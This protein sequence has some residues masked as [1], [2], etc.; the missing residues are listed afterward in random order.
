METLTNTLL[1]AFDSLLKA[2]ADNIYMAE[3]YSTMFALSKEERYATKCD[4]HRQKAKEIEK[5]LKAAYKRA[6]TI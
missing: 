3:H 1:N 2:H 5:A 6:L 4:Y